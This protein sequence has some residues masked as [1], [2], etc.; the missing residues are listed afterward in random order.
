VSASIDWDPLIDAAIAARTNAHA[1]YSGYA[2]GAA[3]MTRSGRIYAGCNVENASYGLTL[4]AERSAIAQMVASGERD[5]IAVV[6]VTRGPKPG[7]PCGMCR[8]TLAE[9]AE[10][11]DVML[12]VEGAPSLRRTLRL[13]ELLPEAFRADAL[14]D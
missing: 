8:Q 10:D 13:S 1:P 12:V 3:V 14:E 2:V 9:F 11:L 4:C 7:T 5:P 6:V